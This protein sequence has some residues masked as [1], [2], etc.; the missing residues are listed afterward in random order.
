LTQQ[1]AE[2]QLNMT[3]TYKLHIKRLLKNLSDDVRYCITYAF[4]DI[5]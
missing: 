1:T 4:G 2:Y 3:L 5:P